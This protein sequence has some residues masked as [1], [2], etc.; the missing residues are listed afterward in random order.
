M[1]TLNEFFL[2]P[3]HPTHRKYE[4]LRSLC[5]EKKAA[6]EVAN[7]F[8][9]SVYTVNAFK[10]DLLQTFKQKHLEP[11]YFFATHSAGRPIDVA[12]SDTKNKIIQLRK[13]NF[14]IL[15]IQTVLHT[16][17]YS[18]T[19]DY[20]FRVL[21]GD[22]FARLPKRTAIEKHS[23]SSET[24]TAPTSRM[25]NWADDN[26]KRF[27]SER[28]LGILTFLP[29]LVELQIEQWIK[30]ANY[31]E[32]S[33]LSSIQM[34]MSFLALKLSGNKR[35]H[36]DD[37]WALDRGFGLFS[38]LNVLPK[39]TTLSTYS[40]RVSRDMNRRFLLAMNKEFR[41]RGLLK[42][43][44]NMDFTTIPHWG[45]ASILEN[46]WSGKR[47]KALK[48]VLVAI[49]QDPDSGVFSYGNA[50]LKHNEQYDFVF[51]FVD[52]WKEQKEQGEPLK[53]LIFDSK[54]TTYQNLEK[55]DKDG[56]KFI[57]LRRRS[58]KLVTATELLPE[59]DWENVI[60]ESGKRKRRV[61]KVHD[62]EIALKEI[63]VKF[64][65]IIV[66][67]NGHDKPSFFITND[68]ERTAA[69]LIRQYGKRWNVE[70]GISEQ[71]EF[72]HLN[73]LSSSIV[74]K[75]DFDLTMTIAAHNIYRTIA[76]DLPGFERETATSLNAKFF[77][78]GGHFTIQN[79]QIIVELKKKRHL[80]LLVEALNKYK[81]KLVSWLGNRQLRFKLDTTS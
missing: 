70:K 65:Q 14:S 56:I 6:H 37:L 24:L 30:I 79:D 33:E 50:E 74:V 51:E 42:G 72:F 21:K 59:S 31:P 71:I 28:G 61:L 35:Y 27:S 22:G 73:S 45:D 66:T 52:F 58:K 23:I 68:R 46:N 40:Y 54:F 7:K 9:Y 2:N 10:R 44:M 26:N 1:E 36:H 41:C 48:S 38:G 17:G 67:D 69:Q 64:R 62:S 3:V 43:T 16:Q 34:V 81:T 57:T 63:N 13:H 8:G 25:V 53:C 55:L 29:L 4:A 78:N 20:I 75:V 76:Q 32:T 11:E 19:H 77:T 15:D 47:N 18:V 5:V 39:T 60:I 12:K 49:C 80:P